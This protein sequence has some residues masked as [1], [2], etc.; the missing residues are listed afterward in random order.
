[1]RS[2]KLAYGLNQN[3]V[4]ANT[5]PQHSIS[6]FK[7]RCFF[8]AGFISV[9]I[10]MAG[11]VLPIL[12]TTPFMLLGAYCFARSSPKWHRWLLQHPIFGEYITAFR[13]KQ[14]LTYKQK[15]RIAV[16][17]TIM[18]SITALH[19]LVAPI[20]LW[21]ALTVWVICM[22]TLYLCRTAD[23]KKQTKPFSPMRGAA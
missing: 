2:A 14:G 9:G 11:I 18:M 19:G 8:A 6:R 3:S 21:V 16:T 12:D 10:G 20:M 17:M 23:P 5:A 4:I 1:M 7:S 22:I 13:E 15:R